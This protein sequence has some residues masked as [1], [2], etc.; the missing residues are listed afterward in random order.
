MEA[1]CKNNDKIIL[2]E[3][4]EEFS[5]PRTEIADDELNNIASKELHRS[6]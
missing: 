3:L 2:T 5:I 6:M 1:Q 4:V